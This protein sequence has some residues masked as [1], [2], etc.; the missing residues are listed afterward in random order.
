[1]L[2]YRLKLARELPPP[3]GT[4]VMASRW[5][6]PAATSPRPSATER[7]ERPR[8]RKAAR[9]QEPSQEVRS[10]PEPPHLTTEPCSYRFKATWN[11]YELFMNLLFE[12]YVFR[13]PMN[14]SEKVRALKRGSDSNVGYAHYRDDIECGHRLLTAIPGCVVPAG[15]V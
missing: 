1:M 5:E 15:W 13:Y 10:C 12:F 11:L 9:D 6:Y 2:I 3:K 8:L 4:E 7:F 14:E